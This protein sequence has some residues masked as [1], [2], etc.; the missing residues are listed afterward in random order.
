MP[1][2]MH[3]T[4][5]SGCRF[6]EPK[7]Q[8]T[9]MEL[10]QP[11]EWGRDVTEGHVPCSSITTNLQ[12]HEAINKETNKGGAEIQKGNND[13]KKLRFWGSIYSVY[14]LLNW[15]TVNFQNHVTYNPLTRHVM[16]C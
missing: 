11:L 8:G 15:G 5:N 9:D 3:P 10:I 6:G 1:Q 4:R 2:S 14:Q 13:K 12:T 7:N 16:Q